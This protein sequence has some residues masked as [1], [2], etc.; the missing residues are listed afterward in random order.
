MENK[1]KLSKL[2]FLKICDELFIKACD[3]NFRP[4][5]HHAKMRYIQNLSDPVLYVESKLGS[6]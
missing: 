2:L 5:M 6:L 3:A 4:V 1:V